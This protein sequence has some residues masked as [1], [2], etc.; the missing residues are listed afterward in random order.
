M[1]SLWSVLVCSEHFSTHILSME[2]FYVIFAIRPRISTADSFFLPSFHACWV[3]INLLNGRVFFPY[4]N[5]ISYNAPL[6]QFLWTWNF[7]WT[8]KFLQLNAVKTSHKYFILHPNRP[9]RLLQEPYGILFLT[10]FWF[11]NKTLIFSDCH[12][13]TALQLAL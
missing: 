13:Q 11:Y 4:E 6:L 12:F 8:D 2:L 7:H 1:L 9:N 10:G 3:C 5:E